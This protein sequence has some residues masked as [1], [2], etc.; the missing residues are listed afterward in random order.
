MNTIAPGCAHRAT[1]DFQRLVASTRPPEDGEDLEDARRGFIATLPD[2][3]IARADG[4]SVWNL[5]AYGFLAQEQAPDTVHPALWRQARL[6][7]E[8]GL[9]EVTERIYQVR[10]FDIANIT[11]IETDSGVVAF[12]AL[13]VPETAAAALA[14]YRAHR[15]PRPLLAVVYSHSHVDHFGGVTGLTSQAEVDAGQVQIIAPAGFMRAAVAEN[16][17][18]GV[19][20]AR[21]AQFQFGNTLPIGPAAQVDSGLGKNL[22]RGRPG[23]I[24]PT[25]EIAEPLETLVIDG[26]TMEFQL[27][28]DTEAPAEMHLFIPSEGAL[29]LAENATHTLHNLCPLRGAKVRDA[30]AW[31]KYLHEALHRW[32]AATQVI[33]GQHHWPTWGNDRALRLLSEQRDLY[34]YLHD[35]TVRLM[36]HGLKAAEIAEQLQLPPGLAGRWHARGYYGSVSHNVKAIYQHYL[37]W[38]DAHPASLNR[39][40][41]VAAA[42]KTVAYMGGAEALLAR[43]RE[44]F[45]RGEFRWVA[46]VTAHLVYAE[47]DNLAARALAAAALEQLGFQAESA[48]W[49]NAYLLGA[50]E[51]RAGPPQ[52]QPGAGAAMLSALSND[53]LFDL[54]AV[55]IVAQRA[56]GMAFTMAWHFSD[57]DEHWLCAL[58]N[59]ALSSLRMPQAPA[60]DAGVRT[61]RATLDALL[62]QQLK[63][64]AALASGHLKLSG[65]TGL[66]AQFFG[67]L[68][69][70][71]GAFP[72]VDAARAA[73]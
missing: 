40:P 15:G 7:V 43:A 68:D 24:A 9:F 2:A 29:N 56:E 59:G 57:S 38:Y 50:H 17:L 3:A 70:F 19:A 48:T 4:T 45:E 65:S 13:M 67:L 22:P 47:P 53:L 61:D 33:L 64:L 12:D 46:E 8:H 51:Y 58:S 52:P 72:V 37:S 1:V 60:A 73:Q 55:R 36:N 25:R 23:L 54:L 28:P 32:G 39:L 5:A 49:R 71:D 66:L 16:V 35:Q 41:P 11:F 34:R 62:Q 63:P 31:S 20:M 10:G 44:D 21:R 26:L 42:R 69:R 18:A 6:N 14:L 30:L 27:A